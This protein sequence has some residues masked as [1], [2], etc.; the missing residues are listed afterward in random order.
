MLQAVINVAS[1]M[2]RHRCGKLHG[3][4]SHSGPARHRSIAI[5]TIAI[6]AYTP[7][8]F[9]APVKWVPVVIL[10]CR[11]VWKNKNDLATR[12]WKSF[13]DVFIRFDT[14]HERDGHTDRRTHRHRMTA[15]A[16][17]DASI[18]RGKNRYIHRYETFRRYKEWLCMKSCH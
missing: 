9:D 5:T 2:R 12:R 1:L 16:A 6:S 11:L 4:S 17:L 10:P 8:A 18:S 13:E 7:S 14:I 15:K 3:G